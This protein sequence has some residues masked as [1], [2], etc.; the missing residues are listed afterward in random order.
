MSL[1]GISIY[2][3]ITLVKKRCVDLNNFYRISDIFGENWKKIENKN[4]RKQQTFQFFPI[5]SKNI[6]DKIKVIKIQ[7]FR[8]LNYQ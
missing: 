7:S 6:A 8:E 3:P 5:F 4:K 2:S 1:D